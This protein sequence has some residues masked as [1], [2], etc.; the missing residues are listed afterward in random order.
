MGAM[1]LTSQ[2]DK[3]FVVKQIF[4]LLQEKC[5]STKD[6]RTMQTK[7]HFLRFL[8]N[9]AQGELSGAF[10]CTHKA[11]LVFGTGFCDSLRRPSYLIYPL[12]FSSPKTGVSRG[13]HCSSLDASEPCWLTGTRSKTLS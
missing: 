6:E 10:L 7:E 9:I 4:D 12:F 3:A 8:G 2:C 13:C 11:I 1:H 5:A